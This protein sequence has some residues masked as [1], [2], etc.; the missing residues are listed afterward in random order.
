VWAPDLRHQ[1][2]EQAAHVARR[3]NNNLI[4]YAA[5]WLTRRHSNNRDGGVFMAVEDSHG[6]GLLITLFAPDA[7]L[8]Y[9]NKP[10]QRLLI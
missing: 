4:V 2:Q 5:T 10:D 8:E 6:I 3:G 1:L 7:G 9:F